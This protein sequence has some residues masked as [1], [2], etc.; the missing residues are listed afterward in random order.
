M[1][2]N[3][4]L[5]AEPGASNYYIKKIF[6]SPEYGEKILSSSEYGELIKDPD[7][8]FHGINTAIWKISSILE[9]GILSKKAARDKGVTL[10]IN[11]EFNEE[12][13][14]SCARSPV[15][16]DALGDQYGAFSCYIR[17]EISFA[18][19][20]ISVAGKHNSDIPGE[21]MADYAILPEAIV[22]LVVPEALLH[23]KIAK[24][25]FLQGGTNATFHLRCQ[26]LLEFLKISDIEDPDLAAAIPTPINITREKRIGL[27]AKFNGLLL[28]YLSSKLDIETACLIDLLRIIMPSGLKLYNTKGF[29]V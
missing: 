17:D 25:N 2:G 8:L 15:H 21:A 24:I 27:E 1:C 6:R 10:G 11:S 9:L 29:E 28:K 16:I 4:I 22:G 14:I 18:I 3:I 5:K 7:I 23:T 26:S 13:C 19:K 12:T 20:G